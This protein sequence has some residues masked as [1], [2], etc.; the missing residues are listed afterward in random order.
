MVTLSGT[1][2]VLADYQLAVKLSLP[3]GTYVVSGC[4]NGGSFNTYRIMVWIQN[5]KTGAARYKNDYGNSVTFT[6]APDE[7]I[8]LISIRT[9]PGWESG[10]TQVF[11]PKLER[12]F[13]YVRQYGKNLCPIASITT[14]ENAAGE[15]DVYIKKHGTYTLSCD[16]TKYEDDTATN[17]KTSIFA[18]YD[19]GTIEEVQGVSDETNEQRDGASRHVSVSITT[20]AKKVLSYFRLFTLD[21]SEEAGRNAKAEN[22]QLEYSAIGTDYTSYIA[23][24]DYPVG[25]DGVTKVNSIH[26]NTTLLT[27][28]NGAIMDVVYNRDATKVVNELATRIAALEAAALN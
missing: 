11:T 10:S 16:V 21:Y 27:D 14:A 26:P 4:P 7:Y 1:A 25:D 3:V 15:V 28:T 23:P 20:N 5:E 8:E 12:K 24:V 13:V 9:S 22:I 17:T 6:L 18:V 19:D 2:S